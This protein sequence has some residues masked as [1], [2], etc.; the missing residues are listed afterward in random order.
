MLQRKIEKN[1]LEWKN[2]LNHK[3]LIIKGCRQCGKT[4]SVLKFAKRI[5]SM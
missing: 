4:A 5:I 3:P 1:L 2:D